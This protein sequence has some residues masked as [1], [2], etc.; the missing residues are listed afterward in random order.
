MGLFHFLFS[1]G[2]GSDFTGVRKASQSISRV[3]YLKEETLNFQ[4]QT[5]KMTVSRAKVRWGPG[6]LGPFTK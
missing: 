6:F 3:C 5:G 4:R 1:Q 2:Y